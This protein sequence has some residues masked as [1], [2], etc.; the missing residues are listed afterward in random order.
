MTIAF[1]VLIYVLGAALTYAVGIYLMYAVVGIY[2]REDGD[3]MA[4]VSLCWF[5][6]VPVLLVCFLLGA[7]ANRIELGVG[8]LV[9][10]QRRPRERAKATDEGPYRSYRP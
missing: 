7:I 4:P 8:R 6:T 2:R 9:E 10:W 3:V 5:V 1:I